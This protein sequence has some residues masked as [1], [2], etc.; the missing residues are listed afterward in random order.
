MNQESKNAQESSRVLVAGV[1]L[2]SQETAKA[3]GVA[4]T[5]LQAWR[6]KRIKLKFYKVGSRSIRYK[7]DDVIALINENIREVA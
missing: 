3:L 1:L 6:S 4:M 5:T 2:T 7:S